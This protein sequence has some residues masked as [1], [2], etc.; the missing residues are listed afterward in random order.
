MQKPLLFIVIL[1]LT[2]LAIEAVR[3][4]SWSPADIEVTPIRNH[5]P[6]KESKTPLIPYDYELPPNIKG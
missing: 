4:F 6:Q 5:L 1:I 2:L 3:E